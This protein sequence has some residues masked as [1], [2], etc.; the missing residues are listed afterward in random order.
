[1]TSYLENKLELLNASQR[2]LDEEKRAIE[3]QIILEIK[4]NSALEMDG[5]IVKF[6]T[7][8][9]ELK[10]LIEGNIL[11]NNIEIARQQLNTDFQ[12]EM[13]EWRT[14]QNS[15]TL[16]S[17]ELESKR[18]IMRQ[19]EIDLRNKFE[20]NELVKLITLEKFKDNLSKKEDRSINTTTHH[21]HKRPWNKELVEIKPEIKV[22]DDIIPI[23]STMIGIMKKQNQRIEELE[24]KILQ[25]R[26]SV[27]IE[28][29]IH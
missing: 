3:E 16:S 7:Q 10:K 6:K 15:G 19:K 14:L 20:N 1:M 27:T 17:S 28:G 21:Y 2:K 18:L 13:S 9:N 5:T 23:F 29:A 11:P 22:Y 24:S 12:K 4:K 26:R 25:N 8:V